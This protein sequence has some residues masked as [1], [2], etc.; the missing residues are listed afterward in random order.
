MYKKIIVQFK[1]FVVLGCALLLI[2]VAHTQD[3]SFHRISTEDGLLDNS[4]ISIAQDSTGFMWFGTINGL[5]R[6]DGSGFKNYMFKTSD[7]GSPAYANI[8]SLYCDSRKTLWVGTSNGLKVYNEQ[9]DIFE[10]VKVFGKDDFTVF[11]IL[12]DNSKRLWAGTTSGLFVKNNTQPNGLFDPFKIGKVSIAVNNIRKIFEDKNRNIWVAT[13]NGLSRMKMQ[14][15]KWLIQNYYSDPKNDQSLSNSFITDV[16]EDLQGNIWIATSNSGVNVLNMATSTFKKI[17]YGTNP[18]SL[19]NNNVRK[20]ICDRKGHMWVGTQEGLSII[21]PNTF[22]VQSFQSEVWDVNSLSKNSIHSLMQD[23]NGSIWIGTYYGG[24]N[25][26]Y[27]Y[28]TIFHN[29]QNTGRGTSLN[30]NVV[31]SI[32]E[33]EQNN[34]WIGT[35]GGGINY[36]N[37]KTGT[38]TIYKNQLNNPSSLG[39]NLVRTI[40]IDKEQNL[41]CGTHGGGLNVLPKGQSGFTRYLYKPDDPTYIHSEIFSV[42]EDHKGRMWV[43]AGTLGLAFFQKNGIQLTPIPIETI[44][45]YKPG[46]MSTALLT[47]KDGAIWVGGNR[48]LYKIQ[49]DVFR[50]VDN[51]VFVNSL[52]E[53]A[54]G[55]IWACLNY[56]GVG[57]YNKHT[58]RFELYSDKDFFSEKR[59]FAALQDNEGNMWLSSS[60]GL[61]KFSPSKNT[62]QVYTTADGLPGNEFNTNA[63]LKTKDGAFYF[64]GIN[65]LTSFYPHQ[66][67]SNLQQ[68][69]MVFTGLKLFNEAV[70][71]GDKSEVLK[72]S[73]NASGSITLRHSQNVIRIEFALLNFIKSNKNRFQYKLDGFDKDWNTTILPS[74]SYTNLSAGTYAFLVKGANNDGVWSTPAMLKINILPPLWRTWWAY[75]LYILAI[76][77][78]LFFLM[79]FLFL[80]ALL[81]KEEALHQIKINFFTNVSHE[82]RTHLALITIPIERLLEIN[83]DNKFLTQQ[84]SIVKNNADR[85]LRLVQ[86]LMDFRKAENNLLQLHFEQENFVPFL[87]NIYETFRESSLQ[88]NIS[89]SFTH[90]NNDIPLYFDKEQLEKVFFN[91]LSNA[92]KFTPNGGRIILSVEQLSDKVIA[93]VEDNGRGIAPEYIDK[94]FGDFFQVPDY[95]VQNTGY[96]IGLALAKN[97]VE[98]H[99]GTIDVKSHNLPESKTIFTVVLP[100][101]CEKSI[102]NTDVISTQTSNIKNTPSKNINTTVL[103]ST[104]A[105]E[106]P[107]TILVVE[108]NAE[109]RQLI[110]QHFDTN[111]NVLEC[112]D[113]MNGWGMAAEVIPD[114]VVSDVMMPEMDGF[115]LCTRLKSD[116][117]TSHIPVVLLTAK[118]AQNDQVTGI[119]TGADIY[120]TKPFST[121]VLELSVKNLLNAREKL[122]E[123][124]AQRTT[125]VIKTEELHY[126][127]SNADKEFLVTLTEL[128]DKHFGE[129]DFG[130]DRL[131]RKIGMSPPVLY[132]KLK[133]VTGLTVNE[134]IKN[135]RMQK[136]AEMLLQPDVSVNEVAFSVGFSDT[137]YFSREFK[138]KFGKT[139]RDYMKRE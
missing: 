74:V 117:R 41:W 42:A 58:N 12:E 38:F 66:I 122:W 2:K 124:F 97:I 32:A 7:A 70:E 75:I 29:I 135:H 109:L 6:H 69:S 47:D 8:V 89:I 17:L 46:F 31:S 33:D 52:Q 10:D 96:G 54:A 4:T 62:V 60:T 57:V 102:S 92:F 100:Q 48:G 123:Y 137:K 67:E 11:S 79:R 73:L 116:K 112:A 40:Y 44:K 30:N 26:Y 91:L 94:I 106:K 50:T 84:L 34:L 139:P 93:K 103:K 3:I 49:N 72:N 22:V 108:D 39:S 35:E 87:Q 19:I 115:E 105:N 88:K 71:I 136:A 56:Q 77:A 111:Y 78:L 95:E 104:D 25:C 51:T 16:A 126:Y 121:R 113:G 125:T 27:A 64:G 128:L 61:I 45:G 15:R 98:Q 101:D 37:K 107:V 85:L 138:K 110:V 83:K 134:V 119:E 65:G 80:Q 9:L 130:V 55:N 118:S 63:Y 36:L 14:G 5:S 21:D 76:V 114:V 20:I 120:V 28:N 82:I 129:E 99:G 127:K 59:I 13:T 81:K 133:A 68:S 86:E 43:A 131:S 18:N 24:V 132:K 23:K 53:D 1:T 90:N